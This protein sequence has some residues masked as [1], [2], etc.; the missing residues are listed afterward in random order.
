[1]STLFSRG[2][3]MLVRDIWASAITENCN[4]YRRTNDTYGSADAVTA[5]RRVLNKKDARLGTGLISENTIVF[6]LQASTV[7]AAPRPHDKIVDADSVTYMINFAE[8][9][10]FDSC[11]RVEATKAV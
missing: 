5:I 10:A 8:Y 3:T 11:Y 9:V 2:R 1:M 7:S 4:L 6:L